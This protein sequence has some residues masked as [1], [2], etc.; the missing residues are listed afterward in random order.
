MFSQGKYS[1][2]DGV[3]FTLAD[4]RTELKRNTFLDKN[5]Q[6]MSSWSSDTE[7][8]AEVAGECHRCNEKNTCFLI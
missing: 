4:N 8:F 1:I 7:L 6:T 2:S 3:A 5:N